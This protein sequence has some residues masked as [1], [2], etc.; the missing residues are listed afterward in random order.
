PN[1]FDGEFHTVSGARYGTQW[2]DQMQVIVQMWAEGGIRLS[3][4]SE[5]YA[6]VYV[7]TY[8]YSRGVGN[9]AS[10]MP[11]GVRSDAGQMI[12][13]FYHKDGSAARVP[14]GAFP[15]MDA[16]IE[17]QLQELDHDAR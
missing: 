11:G 8:H 12:Q 15:E 14:D 6:S 9:F 17:R 7:P 2:H 3:Y 10:A 4:H 13:I 5:D 1:G 16:L